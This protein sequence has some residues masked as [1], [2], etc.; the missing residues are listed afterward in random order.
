MSESLLAGLAEK[1]AHEAFVEG[2]GARVWEGQAPQRQSYR[3]SL[4]DYGTERHL[5]KRHIPLGPGGRY[6]GRHRKPLRY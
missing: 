4:V 2:I 1:F 6:Q 3:P 5:V